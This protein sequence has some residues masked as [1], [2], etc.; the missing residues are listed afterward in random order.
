MRDETGKKSEK[1]GGVSTTRLRA[2]R[3]LRNTRG[4]FAK[5]DEVVARI[6]S[7]SAEETFETSSKYC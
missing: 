6:S 5:F 3:T 7:T 1:S 2:C 4:F